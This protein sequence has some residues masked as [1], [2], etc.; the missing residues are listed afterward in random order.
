M[1][2]EVGCQYENT[3]FLVFF[4]DRNPFWRGSGNR[5][6]AAAEAS[7]AGDSKSLIS[8]ELPYSEGSFL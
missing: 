3:G 1:V 2:E 8:N 4:V 5:N 7:R 6:T